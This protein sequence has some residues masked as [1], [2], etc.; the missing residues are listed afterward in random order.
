MLNISKINSFNQIFN[1]K[2]STKKVDTKSSTVEM[3][4]D[5]KN[6]TIENLKAYHPSFSALKLN[7]QKNLKSKEQLK[8]IK[9]K[10]DKDS[11]AALNRLNASGVLYNSNSN[12]GSTV[13]DNLY[14]IATEPRIM[15]LKDNLIMQEVIKAIDNPF[16]ITQK[17][18]DIPENVAQEIS[19]ETGKEFPNQAYNVTSSA[20]VAA[21][22]EFNLA[23]RNPAEF[24]RFAQGLSSENYSVDKQIKMSDIAEGTAEGIWKL[25]EFNTQSK[26]AKNW[27]DVTI[28]IH[29]DRNAIIR[30]RVQTSYKD[31]DE[32]SCVDVLIQ[33]AILNLCS[34]N[35][36][37]SLIDERQGKFNPDKN[38]L[39][40][41]E[42]TFGEDIIFETPKISVVYQNLDEN[43]KLIGYN[44]Q[45]EE[46]KQ[47]ILQSLKLGQNVIIGYTHFNQEKQVDGGH[48]ITIIGYEEDKNGNGY[49]ICNDTDDDVSSA[50]KISSDKLIPLIHHAGIS[51]EA[52]SKD[53]VVVESWRD[54]LENFKAAINNEN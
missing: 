12:D 24:A 21:S 17:F 25:R 14:K 49:F 15:G 20:C 47:H 6:P 10:L 26:I 44:A 7:A 32:R 3:P 27:E 41:F 4:Q 29:P 43:G 18:G 48:E 46:T 45:P 35:S 51:K 42:K 36:Y 28:K 37:D 2:V 34:Q 5:L 9:S 54:I 31:P 33:S 50:I 52:L 8:V 13:L 19:Q 23:S 16:S 53:D 11:L 22:M 39:T 30:A 1:K 40:D 38:G